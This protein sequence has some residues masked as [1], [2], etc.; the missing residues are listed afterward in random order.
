MKPFDTKIVGILK[1]GGI[2]VIPTDTLYGLVGR[3][4]MPEAVERIYKVRRRDSH[5]PC[6]VLISSLEDLKKFHVAVTDEI[7]TFMDVHKVWPGR[8]S[9][10]F[11]CPGADFEYL[12]R[13]TRSIAFRIPD[14]PELRHLL[15]ETG[16]LIAPS[17]NIEG[18]RAPKTIRFAKVS[19]GESV[20]FYID[21]GE[22]DNLPSTLITFQNHK[23]IIL[24]QGAVDL[25]FK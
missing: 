20:D 9:I 23:P 13:G 21:A 18:D 7:K 19:F 15:A 3:A 16:P 24:R 14:V 2:G 10:V 5:K 8:V 6:I 4:E 22:Q 17:A 1:R 11:P 25:G 12:T